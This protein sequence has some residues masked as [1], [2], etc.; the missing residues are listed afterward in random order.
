MV[1]PRKSR[2]KNKASAKY[3]SIV[4]FLFATGKGQPASVCVLRAKGNQPLSVCYGQGA[5][6]LCLAFGAKLD[7]QTDSTQ[8]EQHRPWASFSISFF[9]PPPPSTISS[10]HHPF[11][12]IHSI[13]FFK[14]FF[15]PFFK[16]ISSNHH[17]P[18]PFLPHQ[19]EHRGHTQ[20][21]THPLPPPPST[22]GCVHRQ[23]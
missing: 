6:S 10:N 12:Q 5:T 18:P 1:L 13:T 11:L 2:G 23:T 15:K 22:T 17:L 8:Q 3:M 9:K 16:S 14:P 20:V 4:I 19:K 7:L 21:Q